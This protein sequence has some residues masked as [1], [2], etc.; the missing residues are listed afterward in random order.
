MKQLFSFLLAGFSVFFLSGCFGNKEV[1][2]PK[3]I[4]VKKEETYKSTQLSKLV[5][6]QEQKVLKRIEKQKVMP[7][8]IIY[9]KKSHKSTPR[10]TKA[11]IM[12]SLML[13]DIDKNGYSIGDTFI[14]NIIKKASWVQGLSNRQNSNISNNVVGGIN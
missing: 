8:D 9:Y 2:T 4:K 10:Q 11:V 1:S 13:A 12:E 6:T 7:R 14:H 3:E 5:K